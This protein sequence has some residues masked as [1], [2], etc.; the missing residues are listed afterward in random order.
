MYS[1][2][3][4]LLLVAFSLCY[5]TSPQLRGV[6]LQLISYQ[7]HI[8]QRPR[9]FR[10]AGGALL[11]G[12]ALAAALWLGPMTGLSVWLVGLMGVGGLVVALAPLGYLNGPALATLYAISLGLEL[13]F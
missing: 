10:A 11:A 5:L 7:A 2:L 9:G 8:N 1:T 4:L 3:F 13:L 12:T 6:K